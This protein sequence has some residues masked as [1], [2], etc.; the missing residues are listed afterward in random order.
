MASYEPFPRP[1]SRSPDALANLPE[2]ARQSPWEAFLD[3]RDDRDEI[4]LALA[5]IDP[6]KPP[7]EGSESVGRWRL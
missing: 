2:D 7:S 6:E 4:I 3:G 1:S 5:A